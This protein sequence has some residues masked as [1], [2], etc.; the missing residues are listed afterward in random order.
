[1]IVR[2]AWLLFFL[3]TFGSLKHASGVEQVAVSKEADRSQVTCGIMSAYTA[4]LS[5]GL[6]PQISNYLKPQYVDEDTGSSSRHLKSRL[7]DNNLYSTEHRQLT[8]ASLRAATNPMLLHF[9]KHVGNSCGGH[10]VLFLGMAD[11][12]FIIY[13][14]ARLQ[15]ISS[16]RAGEL[17]TRW[18]GFGIDVSANEPGVIDQF[19]PVT[20][21]MISKALFLA[22]PMVILYLLNAIVGSSRF[23]ES[24]MT[25]AVAV[26]LYGAA[27]QLFWRDSLF[28]FYDTA[29][30]Q[31]HTPTLNEAFET[32]TF[33]EL[34]RHIQ[35][36]GV[37]IDARPD[38]SKSFR[39]IPNS[40]SISVFSHADQFHSAT[41][42]IGKSEA[43]IAYCNTPTCN[44]AI[45]VAARLK[46]AGYKD[47]RVFKLGMLGYVE[48]TD[49]INDIEES[50]LSQ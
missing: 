24:L 37:V 39:V 18:D 42:G 12:R 29:I 20:W 41:K 50:H 46:E 9:I 14:S 28:H 43:I 7:S 10:W 6:D 4:A 27:C 1:M 21:S 44:W 13:D 26:L 23:I 2:V 36:G 11:G 5:L 8:P 15:P 47:I 31:A 35:K 45:D 40:R 48:L 38:G 25:I 22:L 17:L 33:R 3:G 30:W 19:L 49:E 34:Q 32:V 16:Y